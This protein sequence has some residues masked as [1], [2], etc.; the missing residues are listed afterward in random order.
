MWDL[1]VSVPD[2]C[3]FYFLVNSW[4]QPTRH[5]NTRVRADQ[6]NNNTGES[7]HGMVNV[8]YTI[9]RSHY[10]IRRQDG[11]EQP[12]AIYYKLNNLLRCCAYKA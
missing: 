11:R 8:T 2:L 4:S 9:T 6:S 5:S 1:I 12:T 7:Q 10:T 3:S